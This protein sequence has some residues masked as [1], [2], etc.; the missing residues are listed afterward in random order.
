MPLAAAWLVARRHAWLRKALDLQEP[1]HR[2]VV[3]LS[4]LAA[5]PL[6]FAL[7]AAGPAIRM[8]VGHSVRAST[9]AIFVLD[10]SRSMEAGP[11][12]HAP[13]RLSQAK[14]DAVELRDAIPDVP[15]GV[16]SLTTVLLP[17]LF[18]TPDEQS[19]VQTIDGSL[20]VL[21]PPPP[22]FQPVATSF[23]PLG[24]LGSQGFYKPTTRDRIVVLLTDGESGPFDA[25]G[26]AAGLESSSTSQPLFGQPSRS[27]AGRIKLVIVRVGT[28]VDRIYE[29]AGGIDPSYRPALNAADLVSELARVTAGVAF[30]A[31]ELA[32]ATSTLRADAGTLPAHPS[33]T[34]AAQTATTRL[35]PYVALAAILPLALLVWRRNLTA[36]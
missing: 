18:P 10:V 8:P 36:L 33:H 5:V 11:G 20:A 15:A 34:A 24:A 29:S 31:D 26:V 19:F 1:A 4:C 32:K 27:I 3:E 12:Q 14:A 22:D 35:A 28:A 2:N 30:S 25:R 17:E 6:L 13:N 16:S 7:A 23:D 9:E 21:K